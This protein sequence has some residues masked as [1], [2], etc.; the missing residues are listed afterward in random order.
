MPIT[1]KDPDGQPHTFA[2]GTPTATINTEM[3]R[4]WA[5]RGTPQPPQPTPLTAPGQM[6]P[7]V[8]PG[9][10]TAKPGSDLEAEMVP[11]SEEAQRGLRMVTAGG[12]TNNRNLEQA[13]R[14]LLEKDPTYQARKKQ[15]ETMGATAGKRQAMR[16]AGENILGPFAKL[17]HTFNETPAEVL[18]GAIGPQNTPK[19][20]ETTPTMVPWTNLPIP[21][22]AKP[23]TLDPRTGAPIAG[24]ITPV[25]RAAILNPDNAAA[26][27]AWNLQNLFSHDVHGITNA[28]VTSSGMG[29]QMSD[30]RQAMFDS[31]MRDFMHSSTRREAAKVLDH[32]KTIIQ[33]D[34][35]LTPE[36]ADNILA[37]N[38]QRIAKE[39]QRK[40]LKA[41]SM[42]PPEA[43][44]EFIKNVNAAP[45]DAKHRQRHIT[46]FNKNFNGGN[47]GLA[48]HLLQTFSQS[49]WAP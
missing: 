24:Q 36:E 15:S 12:A 49:P 6:P 37:T 19:L 11:L 26:A 33:N 16:V 40:L 34:F 47:R 21:G 38:M 14:M 10:M 41:A 27:A 13:G 31:A 28:M 23:T 45:N 18:H 35:N 9:T 43:V 2:D 46:L 4:R 8:N 42:T 29:T 48:E 7:G 1:V 3:E 39:E 30:A 17:L 5:A 25:Q 32:A 44:N 22:L 20:Q